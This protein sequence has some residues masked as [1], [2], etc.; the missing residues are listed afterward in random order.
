MQRRKRHLRLKSITFK[1]DGFMQR[2]EFNLNENITCT[3]KEKEHKINSI[4][5]ML[6]LKQIQANINNEVNKKTDSNLNSVKNENNFDSSKIVLKNTNEGLLYDLSNCTTE[7][8]NDDS[9]SIKPEN[10]EKMTSFDREMLNEIENSCSSFPLLDE[11]QYFIEY[12]SDDF[13]VNGESKFLNYYL[14]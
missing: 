3:N 8:K 14:F 1:I 11:C 6:N 7:D 4:K 13:H 2:F 10:D 9:L 5:L 12:N